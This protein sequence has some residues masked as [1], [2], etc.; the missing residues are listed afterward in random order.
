MGNYGVWPTL[1]FWPIAILSMLILG[2]LSSASK[3]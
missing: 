2:A 1:P 3:R